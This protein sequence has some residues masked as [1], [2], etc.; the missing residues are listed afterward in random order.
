MTITCSN[1]KSA[2]IKLLIQLQTKKVLLVRDSLAHATRALIE[3]IFLSGP[4]FRFTAPWRRD[5]QSKSALDLIQNQI[6]S[7]TCSLYQRIKS[8]TENMYSTIQLI[9]C[10][11]FILGAH[12][13]NIP[14]GNWP[15]WRPTYRASN[16]FCARC[17]KAGY[18]C[19]S[20][21]F[22]LE[23]IVWVVYWRV[24]MG[25]VLHAIYSIFRYWPARQSH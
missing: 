3:L 2:F 8:L 1:L 11:V 16:T 24:Q 6:K 10:G 4:I 21:C 22:S 7:A 13:S 25:L 14:N 19:T 18:V 15:A 20:L 9:S 12:K 23:W 17:P 5:F